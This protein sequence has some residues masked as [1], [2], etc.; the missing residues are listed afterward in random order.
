MKKSP[1]KDYLL[2]LENIGTDVYTLMSRGHHDFECFKLQVDQHYPSWVKFLGR[3][4]HL[5]FKRVFN[6]YI[7]CT[8]ETRGCFPV[9]FVTEGIDN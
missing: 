1:N 3:P 9:T 6:K 8:P 4:K 2:V 7:E 5:Y